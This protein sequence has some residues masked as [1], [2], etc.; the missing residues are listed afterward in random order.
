MGTLVQRGKKGECQA[1]IL[2]MGRKNY[3]LAAI[4]SGIFH[5]RGEGLIDEK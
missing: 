3:F 1:H 2:E 5:D 4:I